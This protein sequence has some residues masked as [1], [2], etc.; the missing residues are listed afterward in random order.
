MDH[1]IGKN[2][3]IKLFGAFVKNGIATYMT[4]LHNCVLQTGCDDSYR[5]PLFNPSTKCFR[6][7]RLHSE[8]SIFSFIWFAFLMFFYLQRNYRIRIIFIG[9][10]VVK[11]MTACSAIKLLSFYKIGSSKRDNLFDFLRNLL[12]LTLGSSIFSKPYHKYSVMMTENWP[13]EKYMDLPWW[14]S[15]WVILGVFLASEE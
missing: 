4:W 15:L 1:Q 8:P 14:T 13:P 10:W 12:I 6:R 11:F 7:D 3:R 5:A 2:G 9:P